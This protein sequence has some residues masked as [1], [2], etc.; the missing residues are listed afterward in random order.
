MIFIPNT[1]MP[2]DK[3]S[4]ADIKKESRQAF[5]IWSPKSI[6]KTLRGHRK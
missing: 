5:T 3:K 2:K 6:L 4:K 1:W